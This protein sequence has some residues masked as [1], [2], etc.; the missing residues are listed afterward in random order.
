MRPDVAAWIR[1]PH[2]AA[3]DTEKGGSLACLNFY[4]ASFVWASS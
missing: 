2:S 3:K 4:L 1:P